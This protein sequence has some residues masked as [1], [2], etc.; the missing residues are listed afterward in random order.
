MNFELTSPQPRAIIEA[1][2]EKLGVSTYSDFQETTLQLPEKHGKGKIFGFDFGNGL[3]IFVTDCELQ[4]SWQFTFDMK[5]PPVLLSFDVKYSL[6]Y[7]FNTGYEMSEPLPLQGTISAGTF[8]NAQRFKFSADTRLNLLLIFIQR[9]V[10]FKKYDEVLLE[11]PDNLRALFSDRK[12]KVPFFYNNTYSLSTADIIQKILK[13]ENTGLVRSTFIEAKTAELIH[14]QFKEYQKDLNIPGKKVKLRA[15]D[16]VKLKEARDH[17]V[18]DLHTPPTI[19]ELA[20]QVGINRQKLK[21]G[22]KLLYD[23]T[24]N[25]YLRNERLE[26][27]SILLLKGENVRQAMEQV[28]YANRGYF[29]KKF[30]EKYGVLPKDYLKSIQSKIPD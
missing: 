26:Q 9:E 3:G 10:Y 20:R 12:G 22:F 11:L 14:R 23:A 17:L 30:A 2:A 21:T 8:G 18:H 5:P 1:V 24:I 29:S 4:A 15:P 13:D 25:E 16:I 28:G 27:A 6:D 19:A 7:F